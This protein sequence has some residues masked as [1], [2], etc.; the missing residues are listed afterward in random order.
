LKAAGFGFCSECAKS[1]R[2]RLG[3]GSVYVCARV[4]EPVYLAPDLEAERQ[5]RV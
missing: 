1:E 5:R 3:S 2:R 4:I